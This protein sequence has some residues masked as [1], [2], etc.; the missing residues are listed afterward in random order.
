MA[1]GSQANKPCT[2]IV[3]I[4]IISVVVLSPLASFAQAGSNKAAI[5][6]PESEPYAMTY[7]EWTA[8][9]W[10]W[11]IAIP[12][13]K[14]PIADSTGEK[15]AEQQDGP[16]WFLVGSGGGEAERSCSIPYG[17]AILIPAIDVECSY[18]EDQSLKTE[19]DL[20]ACAKNDQDQV[21]DIY[22]TIDGSDL[23]DEEIYR[24]QSSLFNVTFPTNNV[25]GAPEG[26]TQAVSDGFWVFIKPLPPG[27]HEIH[28]GG[29]LVDYTV[30]A[31]L[32]FVEDST[33]HLTVEAS[34]SIVY[35]E[36]IAF[37][38]KSFE[39]PISSTSTVSNVQFHEESKQLSFTLSG[40]AAGGITAMPIS[41]LVEGP[42]TLMMDS[43]EVTDYGT[44]KNPEMG[45]TTLTFLH[46]DGTHDVTII[47]TSVVP[48]F[49]YSFFIL[50]ALISA[51][52]ILGKTMSI[53]EG[54]PHHNEI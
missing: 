19:D 38:D 43:T 8:M 2:L 48:E 28:V 39:F 53:R 20:R 22:A 46:R 4:M 33:Y 40:G 41:W 12:E 36:A 1:V 14:N 15:C 37:A 47:G 25:F 49:P 52:M 42:Y 50:F 6:T 54:K 13:D 45:E 17:K 7:S 24:V 34:S 35:A 11:F 3:A 10:Q 5:F 23:P 16:V 21:T 18:A 44:S 32:N 29:L 26:P 27:D 30:T 51:I 31:P 9:W